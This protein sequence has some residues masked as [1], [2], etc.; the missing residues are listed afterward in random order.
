MIINE[1][2]V[3]ESKDSVPACYVTGGILLVLGVYWLL[4]SS[5]DW[6]WIVIAAGLLLAWSGKYT[7]SMIEKLYKYIEIIGDKE[8]IS[9]SELA[10][11]TG[12]TE[13]EVVRNLEGIMIYEFF[14]N[15]QIDKENNFFCTRD[16][17]EKYTEKEKQ[18]SINEMEQIMDEMEDSLQGVQTE[19]EKIEGN[20]SKFKINTEVDGQKYVIEWSSTRNGRDSVV[21]E[22]YSETCECCGGTTK[23]KVGGGG[24]CDYCRAPIGSYKEYDD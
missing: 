10:S 8:V 4:F 1:K 12:K 15:T 5:K 11:R 6:A 2:K 23:I 24:I 3:K 14:E 16:Y 19:L 7:N 21:E 17:F 20:V 18:E 9:I 22:Y 13:E